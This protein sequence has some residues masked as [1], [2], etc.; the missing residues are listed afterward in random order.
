VGEN[1]ATVITEYTVPKLPVGRNKPGYRYHLV[2]DEG[3]WRIKSVD[4]SCPGFH[5]I[6][7]KTCVLCH[8]NKWL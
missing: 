8:G 7:D 5:D 3:N 4:L 6:K 2:K 1:H